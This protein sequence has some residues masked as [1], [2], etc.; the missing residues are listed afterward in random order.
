MVSIIKQLLSDPATKEFATR[1]FLGAF[2]AFMI[3]FPIRMISH[4]RSNNPKKSKAEADRLKKLAIQRGHVVTAELVGWE[5]DRVDRLYSASR[6]DRLA[7]YKYTYQGKTYKFRYRDDNPDLELTL[8]FLKNPRKATV[9]GALQE[10]KVPWVLIYL[11]LTVLLSA[12][13][14]R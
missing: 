13:I 11:V 14:G 1:V 9:A 10:K 3:V 8:Y 6:C 12:L 5:N 7:V 2:V 4:A